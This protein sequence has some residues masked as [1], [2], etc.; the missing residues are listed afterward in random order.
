MNIK[1]LLC[2][3]VVSGTTGKLSLSRKSRTCCPRQSERYVCPAGR[4]LAQCPPQSTR[5]KVC[6][7]AHQ[8]QKNTPTNSK[9]HLKPTQKYVPFV[10]LSLEHAHTHTHIHSI[11]LG[12][13]NPNYILQQ[14]PVDGVK[15]KTK[16][17]FL[18]A[19]I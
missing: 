1:L 8:Q 15:K 19:I 4:Y 14:G 12:V 16:Q 5:P 6:R 17:L 10:C 2:V 3:S 11:A 13:F 7:C 9:W 18:S